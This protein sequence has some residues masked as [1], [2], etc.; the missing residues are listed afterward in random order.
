MPEALGCSWFTLA[1]TGIVIVVYFDRVRK[2]DVQVFDR[3]V[4]KDM[5]QSN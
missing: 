2:W 3:H 1:H 4:V 5:L